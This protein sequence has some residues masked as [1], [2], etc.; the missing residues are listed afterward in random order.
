MICYI[1]LR[2]TS[3]FGLSQFENSYQANFNI[4]IGLYDIFNHLLGRYALKNI[5]YGIY[6]FFNFD[7]LYLLFS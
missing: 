7:I 4:F 3:L 5:L 6:Q 2:Q 1:L